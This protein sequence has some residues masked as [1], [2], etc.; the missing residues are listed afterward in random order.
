MTYHMTRLVDG[1]L[2][3]AEERVRA[4]LAL[5][6]FGVLSRIDVSATLKTKINVDYLPY[7]ILGACNPKMAHKALQ[8]DDKIGVMLPCNI[9]LQSKNGKIEVSAIDP[10]ESIGRT[11]NDA[12]KG[13]ATSVKQSLQSV[14]DNI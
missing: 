3:E 9:I 12:L 10:M 11:G 6:G 8:L 2:E 13:P 4:A 7:V 14:L 1:N 5:E